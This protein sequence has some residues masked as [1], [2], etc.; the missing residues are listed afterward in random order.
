MLKY[1]TSVLFYLN[2]QKPG[3]VRLVKRQLDA[4]LHVF[5]PAGMYDLAIHLFQCLFLRQAVLLFHSRQQLLLIFH[6]VTQPVCLQLL[7]IL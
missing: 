5:Q 6:Q 7:W 1:P 2:Q 3:N 4:L